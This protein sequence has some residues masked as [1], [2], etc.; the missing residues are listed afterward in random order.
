MTK[1]TDHVIIIVYVIQ[2]GDIKFYMR[3][4]LKILNSSRPSLSVMGKHF[5]LPAKAV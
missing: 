5:C 4:D 2:K 1:A 3:D